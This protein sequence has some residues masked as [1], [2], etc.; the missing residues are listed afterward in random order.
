MQLLDS[1]ISS[2]TK[3]LSGEDAFKLN[4][5]YGFPIDLTVEILA[6]RGITV[7]REGYDKLMKE[8]KLRARNA[9]KNAGADAWEGEGNVIE[10]MPAT[11][12]VG[13]DTIESTGKVLAIVKEGERVDSASAG[14]EITLVL[15][16]TSFYAESGGQVGDVGKIESDGVIINVTDTQKNHSSVFMHTAMVQVGEVKVGDT[17]ST[18]VDAE[19]RS[20]TERNHTVAH[21]LQAAL[22]K[23]LGTHVEQAGQYV[24]SDAVRFDFTH[25][26]AMTPEEI[27]KVEDLVN[28]EIFKSIDVDR[29]EMPIDEARKLGAM[30]LFGEKYGDIVR[31]VK[32]DD[33]SIEFC[34]GTHISNTARIG[35][36]KI[37]SESS[38][39]SGVRRIEGVTGKGVM[40]RLNSLNSMIN[41]SAAAMKLN[42][43]ND[44]PRRSAQ[45][46]AE[47]KEK[48]KAIE[49]LS[50]QLAKIQLESKLSNAV[51]YKGVKLVT[52]VLKNTTPDALRQMCDQIKDT[53]A[54]GVAV[55]ACI[56]G[57]KANICAAVGKDAVKL[58]AHA[59]NIVR[60]V[61]KLAGGN[62][63]GRP[64]SAMAG[65]KDISKVEGAVAQV[66][67]ILDSMLK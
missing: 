22:R 4:D 50:A 1:Y 19:T 52:A 54:N 61:A 56:N 33:F 24:N 10:D 15:D 30:A 5:T 49:K 3:E 18:K 39:A 46:T 31:V 29:R 2:D 20:A 51:D 28:E 66:E 60:E 17:V 47:L 16:K 58:G 27:Q 57:E 67:S 42:N 48:D 11:E 53:M 43:V 26:S 37:I 44:L 23:V 45:L 6:E 14:D 8:Q 35:M 38:V 64:D 21:L 32:V 36:F 63:G 12:F 59:G 62:G 65:A 55:L 40:E 13:Y 34:G 9:R 7:D 41:E 25:F